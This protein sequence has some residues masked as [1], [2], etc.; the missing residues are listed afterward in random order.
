MED[1]DEERINGR[2]VVWVKCPECGLE[3]W[4]SRN[5]VRHANYTKLCKRCYRKVA[6]YSWR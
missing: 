6:G 4:I 2:M 1:G 3:R 5:S